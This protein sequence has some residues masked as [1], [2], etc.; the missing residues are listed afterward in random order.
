MI[1]DSCVSANDRALVTLRLRILYLAIYV[2]ATNRHDIYVV[3]CNSVIRYV[4]RAENKFVQLIAY[5]TTKRKRV[6]LI[7]CLHDGVGF[8]TT[9]SPNYLTKV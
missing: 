3:H 1:Y 9:V 7:S 6:A 4:F 8:I 5:I 2:V